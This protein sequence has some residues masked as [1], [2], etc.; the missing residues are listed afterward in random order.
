MHQRAAPCCV[1][2]DIV[3]TQTHARSISPPDS[4]S[5]SSGASQ[6]R[7]ASLHSSSHVT[8]RTL[9]DLDSVRRSAHRSVGTLADSRGGFRE[10]TASS[11]T[12]SRC[13]NVRASVRPA[14][15]D[16]PTR[17]QRHCELL[18]RVLAREARVRG[19]IPIGVE[20]LGALHRRC[21]KRAAV[22]ACG[23]IAGRLCRCA[24][25][26][27]R[28]HR[29]VAAAR[30]ARRRP[31]VL[32]RSLFGG[33]NPT[34][35]PLPVPAQVLVHEETAAYVTAPSATASGGEPC[36]RSGSA[37]LQSGKDERRPDR[38]ESGSGSTVAV[39]AGAHGRRHGRG[40]ARRAACESARRTRAAVRG[41]RAGCVRPRQGQTPWSDDAAAVVSDIDR[42]AT[43][44]ASK[45]LEMVDDFVGVL[46]MCQDVE[47]E[48][49]ALARVGAYLRDRLQASSVAFVVREGSASACADAHRLRDRRR[50]SRPAHDRDRAWRSVRRTPRDR[51]ESAC[52]V[53]H[54]AEVIG[55]VW[56]RW[57]AGTPVASHQA[58]TLLGIAA[59]ATAPSV[60]LALARAQPVASRGNPI[61]EL[62]GESDA[63]VAVREAIV[64]AAASP[65]PVIIE[66][67]SGS[68]KEL[69]ARAIHARSARRDRRFC[70]INCAALVDDLV[71]AELF[72]HV[73]G[74]FTG[75][76]ADRPGRVR[77]C[78]RR[79]A[80]PR[81]DRRA[82]RPRAGQAAARAAGGRDPAAR[83][84]HGPQGRRA[85]RGGDEPSACAR[86]S[87]RA[88]SAPISGIASTSSASRCRRCASAS[89]ICPPLVAPSLAR[90]G[91]TDGQP[92]GAVAG[93]GRRAGGC[94]T[95][96]AT[97]ASCRMCSP[98]CSCRRPRA[99]L[100]GP[101]GAAVAHR[102]RGGARAR[103]HAG[104]RAAAIRG[105]LRARRTGA[106][107]R[108]HGHGRAR[109]R[110]ES[111]GAVEADGP[112]GHC[113][114][115]RR[116][117]RR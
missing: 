91:R 37:S 32:V 68:G 111:A 45:G 4:A 14:A 53:R 74:A 29:G 94:T 115:C 50:R 26:L 79:H 30:A 10:Q 11:A 102:A 2:I 15:F 98:R 78:Q 100:I 33:S 114:G 107:R 59:A 75:A 18:R 42:H 96:R 93:D 28:R 67:E 8:A 66:G 25:T 5:T 57:S 116:S 69:A 6:P 52:P 51:S 34:R 22:L 17:H 41:A 81:R 48:Q 88:P 49:T 3:V 13:W 99:G 31:H 72:G 73:R 87:P 23:S 12:S 83:R 54:A 86:K 105:A 90:A 70:A 97:S 92:R 1:S 82:R 43:A 84:D 71:E 61:P 76:S 117:R 19:W 39:A 104:R 47:D 38:S 24:R 60:R 77:G 21:R 62:I 27:G 101:I 64:R 7:A 103:R 55:A 63:M 113:R 36:S 106:R 35:W 65:F 40:A 110:A 80:V 109:P 56:C 46:Q 9:I 112:A 44:K 108:P 58:S 16:L 95:G 20:V 89:K 85:D